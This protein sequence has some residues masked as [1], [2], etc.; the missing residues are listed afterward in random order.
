M[1]HFSLPCVELGMDT[2]KSN[3]AKILALCAF[4]TLSSCV[5]TQETPMQAVENVE[6]ERFMGNW[7]VV[8]G[9]PTF[10]ERNATNPLE[11]YQLNDDGTVATTFTFNKSTP[12]GPQKTLNMTAYVNALPGNGVWGMQ[13]I[14]PIKAD[15]RIAYL[16][17]EYQTTIIARN[18]RDYL[19][20][21]ARTPGVSEETLADL[22]QRA[23]DLGYE[24]DKIQLTNWQQPLESQE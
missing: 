14:W 16:D 5:S 4:I 13:W 8:A 10:P 12:T 17:S 15:Y 11:H 3:L 22:I 6:L 23:V 24:Q 1:I 21:M 19:W 18:K 9:I 20:V 7:Y 2:T